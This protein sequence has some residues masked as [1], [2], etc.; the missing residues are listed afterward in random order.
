MIKVDTKIQNL[1]GGPPVLHICVFEDGEMERKSS[2]D[3]CATFRYRHEGEQAANLLEGLGHG[4]AAQRI[5]G[6]VTQLPEG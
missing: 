1:F 3:Y 4:D 2:T 5:R 6:L